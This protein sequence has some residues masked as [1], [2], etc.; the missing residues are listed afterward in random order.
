[1]ILD[2]AD[3]S[4]L[5]VASA[6]SL[7]RLE[8]L[9]RLRS[10]DTP[11][12]LMITHIIESYWIPSQKKTKSKLQV[13]RI[14]QNCKSF[15]C[16]TNFTRDTPS[17]V[18]TSIVEVTEWTRFCPQTDGRRETSIPRFHLRWWKNTYDVFN[19]YVP[20]HPW[21]HQA[22]TRTSVD[23]SS[24]RTNNEISLKAISQEIPQ[25]SIT[26]ISL[27]IIIKNSFKSPRGPW[28]NSSSPSAT[29]MYQWIRSALVQIMACRLFSAKPLSKPMLDYCQL[30][31]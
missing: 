22:I 25:P 24:L 11:C 2:T 12:R 9:E 18:P 30:D 17:E 16:E 28:V 31:P 7:M 5:T 15:N 4:D 20:V 10:E 6:F 27:K 23:W 29:Y 26:K 1:M 13:L 3:A 14:C 19:D 8:Q 21:Q